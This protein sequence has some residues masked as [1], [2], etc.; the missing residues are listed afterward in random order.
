[1]TYVSSSGTRVNL[2]GVWNTVPVSHGLLQLGQA[3][4]VGVRGRAGVARGQGRSHALRLAQ[5]GADDARVLGEPPISPREK[6]GEPVP[7]E[8]CWLISTMPYYWNLYIY[9]MIAMGLGTQVMQEPDRQ[10][11]ARGG[12]I[13]EAKDL[14]RAN[15][16]QYIK[17]EAW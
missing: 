16:E 12:H 8:T 1:M 3:A 2:I 13:N 7:G 10:W 5:E 4:D 9:Q 15:L 14:F 11:K 6:Y 17:L